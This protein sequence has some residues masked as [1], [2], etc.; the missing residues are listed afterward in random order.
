MFQ[1]I[2]LFFLFFFSIL[3]ANAQTFSKEIIVGKASYNCN[4]PSISINPNNPKNIA[5]ATNKNHFF[6]SNN[7][8]KNFKHYIA[9]STLGVYGD[10]VLYFTS[11]H[12]LYYI[13]LAQNKKFDWPESFDQ[14]VIQKSINHGKTLNN[15]IGIGKN[16][17]MQDK[18]WISVDEN[19]NKNSYGNVYITWTQFDK[20][21]SE[22]KND[23]SRILFAY[24]KNEGKIFSNPIIISDTSGDCKDGNNTVEGATTCIDTNGNIYVAWAAF[25]N[26]YFDKSIDKGKSFGKD[27]IIMKCSSGWSLNVP[28]FS[29]TNGLPFLNCDNYGN[30]FVVTSYEKNTFNNVFISKSENNGDTWSEAIS[31][32]N[33]DSTHYF[34]PHAFLDKTTGNYYI[35]YYQSKNFQT[36]IILSYKIFG[37]KNFKHLKV[38]TS[39][40][41][42]NN[43]KLFMGDYI[44][45]CAVK[46]QISI[47]WTEK[48][49]TN[50]VV[51]T[52]NIF[53]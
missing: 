35:V 23:S 12:I 3:N 38:N 29:R 14:I 36:N 41:K 31:L 49:N 6:Y 21:G 7:F 53:L 50:T 15:G 17:K 47:V 40:F 26:I 30:M 11:N 16:G 37:E 28:G 51:K 20:Y 24:S 13:H 10:P 39:S 52:R 27:K 18:P 34:M 42:L 5:I 48:Q 46:N 9:K 8:G 25:G 45:V 2:S 4:E 33:D 32:Q 43:D 44:N 1:K 22:N 19:I